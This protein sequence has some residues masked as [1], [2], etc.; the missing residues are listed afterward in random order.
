MNMKSS[1]RKNTRNEHRSG[2]SAMF[3]YD[4][5]AVERFRKN[6]PRA[7]WND[8]LKAWFVPGKTAARR[9]DRWL[10][11][12]AAGSD[13]YADM[14]G[15]DAYLFDPV[16]SK[17]LH[18]HDDRLEVK[19]PY[20]PTVVNAMREV[21]FAS[22]VADRRAWTIPYRSYEE[23]RRRWDRIEAAAKRNEPDERKRRQAER[24][25][26]EE[27]RASRARACERRRRRHPL[28]TNELPPLGRPVMTRAY[29]I[30]V[31]TAFDGELVEPEILRAFYAD[32]PPN[33]DY[34]WGRWRPAR[35]EELVKTWPSRQASQSNTAGVVWWQPTLDELR[36]A[37]KAAR[38]L[39]RRLTAVSSSSQRLGA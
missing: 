39:E 34:I 23:L 32:L 15:R 8:E 11:Q 4:R 37:R 28:L 12:E 5:M 33:D 9:F 16:V 25:G 31:F 17:Y 7:R 22:W 21:P 19:T 1:D 2:A 3:P 20:S 26:S 18:V 10:E 24:R 6:F 14:K 35:L 38:A 36:A 13:V 29:R 27:D 30:V